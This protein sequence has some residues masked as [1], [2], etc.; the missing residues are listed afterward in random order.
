LAARAR[1]ASKA[2]PG[3]PNQSAKDQTAG[4]MMQISAHRRRRLLSQ[5]FACSLL[6]HTHLRPHFAPHFG[7]VAWKCFGLPTF[8]SQFLSIGEFF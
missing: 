6:A 2:A 1:A 4:P 3:R 7:V 8:C 5:S